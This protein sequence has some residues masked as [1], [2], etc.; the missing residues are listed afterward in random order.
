[1]LYSILFHKPRSIT[2]SRWLG[3]AWSKKYRSIAFTQRELFD[4]KRNQVCIRFRILLDNLSLTHVRSSNPHA[5]RGHVGNL[6]V[7]GI[8]FT[9]P[10]V[11]RRVV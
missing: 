8:M 6:H 11:T 1:M 3:K 7:N 2:H 4:Q 9:V 10:F 5:K